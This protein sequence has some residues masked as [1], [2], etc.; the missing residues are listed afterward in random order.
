MRPSPD[1]HHRIL[2]DLAN[3]FR[4]PLKRFF[5]RRL[6]DRPDSDDLVQE[7]FVRL[8]RQGQLDSIEHL[9]AYVFQI[10]AN[11]L[12]DHARRWSVRFEESHAGELD[13]AQIEGGF[14]PERVLLGKESVER[15]IAGLF[16][17][18]EKTRVIFSLYHFDSVSQ[19]EIARRLG[20]SIS[21]VEKHMGRA[22][23]HLLG[24]LG[25][26]K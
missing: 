13:D 21:T 2:D 25:D 7:V 24:I 16:E 12:R 8:T 17:L 14:S 20:M 3:R 19:V 11:V 1:P 10:A 15:L 9:D 6:K 18:P 23:A 22:N 4:S 5:E 26:P